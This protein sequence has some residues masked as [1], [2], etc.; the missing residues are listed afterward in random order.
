MSVIFTLL[1]V[2]VALCASERSRVSPYVG[3]A[4]CEIAPT[5]KLLHFRSPFRTY[6][7]TLKE[8]ARNV[9]V[10]VHHVTFHAYCFYPPPSA[11]AVENRTATFE[12]FCWACTSQEYMDYIESEN[13]YL[14]KVLTLTVGGVLV[15]CALFI[16]VEHLVRC[17]CRREKTESEVA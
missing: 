10:G 3:V 2:G 6:V 11:V 9:A 8:S 7:Y 13:R 16:G 1:S 17:C 4:K 12:T 5:D 15:L 14:M